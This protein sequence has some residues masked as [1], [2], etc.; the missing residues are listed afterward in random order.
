MTTTIKLRSPRELGAALR[1]LGKNM[2]G[3]VVEA[4]RRTARWGATDALRVSVESEP[5]PRATGTY[6]RS[7]I[8]TKLPDGAVLSNSS[9]HGRFV[10]L[11]R[12]PGKAPPVQVIL[13]WMIIKKIDKKLGKALG[14][15]SAGKF[16][17]IGG[18]QLEAV[19]RR[20][21]RAIGRRGIKGRFVFRRLVPRMRKRLQ[22]EMSIEMRKAFE[23]SAK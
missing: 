21:A 11:G 9:R 12:D 7:F 16:Q 23:R 13:E 14:R 15:D 6:E 17:S 2:N 10:E 19:A 22:I 20:I 1:K 5:R 8:V 18:A 3:G 4:L